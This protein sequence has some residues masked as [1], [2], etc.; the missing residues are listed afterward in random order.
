MQK[1]I[2]FAISMM[3]S[4]ATFANLS[5]AEKNKIMA[6]RAKTLASVTNRIML[7]DSFD[8][9]SG[10]H[11]GYHITTCQY[12]LGINYCKKNVADT[13]LASAAKT[14]HDVR[15]MGKYVVV[16][17]GSNVSVSDEESEVT[18]IVLVDNKNKEIKTTSIQVKKGTTVTY[19]PKY[20]TV[21][22][23]IENL[24]G[25]GDWGD[26]Q[27]PVVLELDADSDE[28]R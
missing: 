8:Y 19:T 9:K 12:P 20:I 6:D 26:E 3:I 11:K 23:D 25:V 22:G 24:V 2:A 1:I 5:V 15:F 14:K 10:K 18:G 21:G 7:I 17:A 4:T 13:I 28:L 16:T 27:D